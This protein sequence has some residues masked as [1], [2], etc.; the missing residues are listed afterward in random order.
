MNSLTFCLSE[1]SF[2]LSSFLRNILLIDNFVEFFPLIHLEFLLQF[3]LTFHVSFE[4]SVVGFSITP[5][6]VMTFFLAIF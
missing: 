1:Y 6:D 2:R 5:F 3:I 4:T